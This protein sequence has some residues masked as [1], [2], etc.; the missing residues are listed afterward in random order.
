LTFYV[1]S[2]KEHLPE[3]GDN[4]WPKQAAGYAV[5]NTINYKSVPAIIGRISYAA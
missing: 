1:T 4:R 2:V 3:D 5:Y